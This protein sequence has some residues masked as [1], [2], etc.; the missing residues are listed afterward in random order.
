MAT[1]ALFAFLHFLA[2]FG[3]F[4]TVFLQWQTMSPCSRIPPEPL[5]NRLPWGQ[6]DPQLR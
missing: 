2:V 3:V 5:I 6:K 1:S 4:A